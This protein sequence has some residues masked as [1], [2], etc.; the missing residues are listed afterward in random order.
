MGRQQVYPVSK[1]PDSEIDYGRNWG[2]DPVSGDPGWLQDGES[3]V[4]ST[5]E[6]TADR[7]NPATLIES[8]EGTGIF[9]NGTLTGIYLEN[10]TPGIQ[11]TLTNRIVAVNSSKGTTRIEKKAGIINCCLR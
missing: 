10:G 5:W 1:H 9:A 8:S 2:I 4:E 11:Y 3:I 7:E 6:I